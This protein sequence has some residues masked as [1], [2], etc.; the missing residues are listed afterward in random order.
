MK[1]LHRLTMLL[2][3]LLSVSMLM[4]QP[5]GGGRGGDRRGGRD[6]GSRRSGGPGMMM[7]MIMRYDTNGNLQVEED[8]LKVH[9]ENLLEKSATLYE[10]ILSEYDA[11]G[12]GALNEEE[13]KESRSLTGT[14]MEIQRADEDNDWKL[15]EEELSQIWDRTAERCQRMNEG[16]LERYDENKDGKLNG[17]ETAEI[18]EQMEKIEK[19][20]QQR[21]GGAGGRDRGRDAPRGERDQDDRDRRNRR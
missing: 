5:G 13:T 3:V 14:I 2:G 1:T 16:L 10:F 15:S 17:E 20:M 12:N 6:G 4:A 7:M 18:K 19:F 9:L 8:E 11:D 21:G